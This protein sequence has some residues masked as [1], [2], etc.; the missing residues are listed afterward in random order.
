MYVFISWWLWHSSPPWQSHL[1]PWIPN[2]ALLVQQNIT[3]T[4]RTTGKIMSD[5]PMLVEVKSH[6][7]NLVQAMPM[8]NAC[9]HW[10]PV[11]WMVNDID[12]LIYVDVFSGTETQFGIECCWHEHVS[13]YK[14]QKFL[15]QLFQKTS[16][17]SDQLTRDYTL[18]W[19]LTVF[20]IF[21]IKA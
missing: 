10:G 1:S 16:L 11:E 4:Y 5:C 7:K 13:Q 18:S 14:V 2:Y 20:K 19:L 15:L 8:P 21:W 17:A 9:L 3:S 12:L 6:W